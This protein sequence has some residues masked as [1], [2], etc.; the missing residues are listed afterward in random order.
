MRKQQ[1]TLW[2]REEG[3]S[4]TEFALILILIAIVT[5]A[6]LLIMGDDIRV[7]IVTAWQSLF[8]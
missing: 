2:Q 3:Q 6:I 7:W 8:P 4:F 1:L 5:M